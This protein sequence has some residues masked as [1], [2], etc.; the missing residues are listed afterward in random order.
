MPISNGANQGATPARAKAEKLQLIV[1]V[2][3]L[4]GYQ[5]LGAFSSD[6]QG[7]ERIQES[8]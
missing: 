8:S 4:L 6:A 3:P 2:W 7:L 1:G 5:A